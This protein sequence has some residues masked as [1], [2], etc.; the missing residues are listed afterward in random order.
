MYSTDLGASIFHVK[1]V[2][3]KFLII[4]RITF[5][6][7]LDLSTKF[8]SISH[9]DVLSF[10]SRLDSLLEF[11]SGEAKFSACLEKK[12]LLQYVHHCEFRQR[13]FHLPHNA[14]PIIAEI[15]WSIFTS[16]SFTAFLQLI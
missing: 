7:L 5:I 14:P 15:L 6:H 1:V 12:I 8:K 2:N 11:L 13:H 10:L 3:Q 16:S 4:F 9:D